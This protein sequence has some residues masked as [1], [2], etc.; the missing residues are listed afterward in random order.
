M[1]YYTHQVRKKSR[2]E[3]NPYTIY[4]MIILCLF[5]VFGFLLSVCFQVPAET[6]PVDWP[7]LADLASQEPAEWDPGR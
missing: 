3:I 1:I 6:V 4:D 5:F 2:F 7:Q